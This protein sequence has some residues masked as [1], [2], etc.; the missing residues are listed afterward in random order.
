MAKHFSF[1]AENVTPLSQNNRSTALIAKL[2]NDLT[3]AHN[4]K[5]GIGTMPK[6]PRISGSLQAKV[7][8]I[9][10]VP[11]YK[12]ADNISKPLWDS[13]NGHAYVD[14]EQIKYLETLKINV[15]TRDIFQLD[16]TDIDI[17]DLQVLLDFLDNTGGSKERILYVNVSDYESNKVRF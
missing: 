3:V 1:I 15:T 2:R 6:T 12:D 8:Y 10:R 16:I 7:F 11:D 13:L 9:H 14:D 17:F 5:Y 4:I